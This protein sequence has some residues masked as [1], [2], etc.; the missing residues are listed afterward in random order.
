MSVQTVV[1][2]SRSCETTTSV[3]F[4]FC[5]Y[6]SSQMTACRSRWLVGS[7]SS[8]S[9]GLRKSARASEMRIRQPPEKD[10]VGHFF[11]SSR[12]WS[13]DRMVDARVSAESA[14]MSASSSYT[15]RSR[16]ASSPSGSNSSSISICPSSSTSFRMNIFLPWKRTVAPI[17][18]SVAAPFSPHFIIL[19]GS[20]QYRSPPFSM[21]ASSFSC[22]ASSSVRR[23]SADTTI[24]SAEISSDAST[25]CSTRSTSML[26][27]MPFWMSS[28]PPRPI[29]VISVDLPQPLGPINP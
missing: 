29:A 16:S 26:G 13:P 1:R 21:A 12:N 20:A 17:E 24:C 23:S 25:S 4:H 8:K 10:D 19:L 18:R 3:C 5:K 22:S 6:P 7:S 28:L 14:P 11:C 2:K 9:R 15:S 27:G